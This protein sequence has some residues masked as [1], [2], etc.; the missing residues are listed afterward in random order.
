MGHWVSEVHLAVTLAT[1]IV[2][3]SRLAGDSERSQQVT[4]THSLGC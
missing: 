2:R 1:G 4:N 3:Y